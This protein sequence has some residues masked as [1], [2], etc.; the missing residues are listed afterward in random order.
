M[1][2]GPFAAMMLADMG[3]EVA[4][5]D[6]YVPGRDLPDTERRVRSQDPGKYVLHRGRRSLGLN[7]KAPGAIETALRMVERADVLIEGYRPGVM[8]RLGLGPDRCLARNVKLVYG[9][10]TGW[11]QGGPL[12][13]RAGHD[14]NYIALSG[15]LA[16]CA[17][18][19]ERPVP[20]V[21]LVGDMGGGGLML[22]YGVVC[23][24]LHAERTGR[25]QIV[26]SA[27]VDGSAALTT[28]LYG[29]G[30]QGRWSEEPGTNFADTGAHYYEVYETAD[31][32]HIAVGAIEPRFYGMLLERL[33]LPPETEAEQNDRSTWPERKRQFAD[34]AVRRLGRVRE[35]GA[36]DGG[37]A[38][39]PAQHGARHLHRGRRCGA[40]GADAPVQRHP[41][42]AHPSSAGARGTRGRGAGALRVR[43]RREAATEV[44]GCRRMTPGLK[45][46]NLLGCYR[47]PLSVLTRKASSTS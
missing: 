14:I 10:M 1:G 2:P 11:G 18:V 42:P 29:M 16:A 4:R 45:T 23:A 30:A 28:M 7:L 17:R 26:D 44:G 13:P 36:D 35:P 27:I 19:G 3:A 38:R 6:R 37:G 43:R 31:G 39:P 8:E 20:P 22:A 21:N 15:A 46:Y 25:G 9:R 24:V 12:A 47:I 33:G 41:R 34:E 5:I 40:A 32:R